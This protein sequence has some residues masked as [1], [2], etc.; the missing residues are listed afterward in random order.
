MNDQYFIERA[1]LQRRLS[2]IDSMDEGKRIAEK[3][4][5]LDNLIA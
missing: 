3:I 5:E 4:S 2:E 1:R